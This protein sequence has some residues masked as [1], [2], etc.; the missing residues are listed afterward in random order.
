MEVERPLCQVEGVCYSDRPGSR[1]NTGPIQE[2]R[3]TTDTIL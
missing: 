2:P 3:T 1:S